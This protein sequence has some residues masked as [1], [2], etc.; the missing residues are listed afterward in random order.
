M[1][2]TN[3]LD[4]QDARN[5]KQA[6]ADINPMF[7]WLG[8][9][10]LKAGTKNSR[11]AMEVKEQHSNTFGVCHGGIIFAFADLALGFT[12]NARGEKSVTASASMDFLRPVMLGA[13]L[14]ADVQETTIS[15]RNGF[16]KVVL[17]VEDD[18][19]TAVGLMHGRMR[20]LGGPVI[21]AG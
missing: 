6:M 1:P 3:P 21:D 15:G 9:E 5:K 17:S 4:D 14:I 2:Q 7:Q 12:C 16:Y 13:R 20:I 18:P 19:E 10:V 8:I 11:F